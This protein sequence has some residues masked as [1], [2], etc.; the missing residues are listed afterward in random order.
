LTPTPPAA[1][2][3]VVVTAPR[4]APL[5]GEAAF[6]AK[7]LGPVEL[8]RGP[9]LDDALAR[10]PGVS[11]F[12]RNGSAAA[13]PTVQGV[14]LRAI[15]PSGAGRALVLL[16]GA[17]V[18]DPFGGWVIWTALPPE[19]LSAA[20][21]VRGAGAGPYGAGALTG[22]VSL[23]EAAA[24]P[25]LSALDVSAGSREGWRIAAVGG[26]PGVLISASAEGGDGFIPV[27]RDRRGPVDTPLK[28][29]AR[30]AAFRVQHAWGDVAGSARFGVYEERRGAGLAGAA[31]SGSGAS[32][33][34][35]LARPAAPATLGWRTQ[36]WIR[37]SDLAN[38]SVAVSAGRTIA[39][40][41]NEQYST[42]ALGVGFNAAVQAPS[43]RPTTW[44]LGVDARLAQGV[45]RERFR[46]LDGAFTRGRE[47]GGETLVAGL[48]AEASH[49]SGPWLA[50]GGVRLDAWRSRDATRREW[51]L[52]TGQTTLDQP[53][54]DA[55]G[56]T[57][58]ARIGLR[59][60]LAGT[61]YLRAA[62]YAGFRPPTLNELHRPFRVGNDITEANPSLRPERLQG[63]EV[64]A[65]GAGWTLT[66]F[67]NRLLDPITNVTLGVGPATFPTAGFVPAGGVLRRR[68]N[69]GA[70][71]AWGIEGDA[72]GDLG[73]SVDWRLAFAATRARVD[74]GAANPQLTGKRPA[75]API[76]SA[77]AGADWRPTQAIRFSLDGV[78]ESRRFD[79]DLNSRVLG[80][81]L[82]LDGRAALRIS[83][84]SELYL[85][86]ENLAG[87]RIETAETADG[88]ESYAAPRTVR[89][90]FSFRR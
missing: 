9:R 28:L 75:Q 80:P 74:G 29:S 58:T 31:A 71:T 53:S 39:T 4:L 13:N 38:S 59:Y 10:T 73:A 78:Y 23:Q 68:Q 42:P 33:T 46:F 47:A 62:A 22:V 15:A 18:N 3:T 26:G 66:V 40:P 85:A 25:A 50:T 82:R 64:G 19:A 45:E 60:A 48:Y 24:G 37:A 41:A 70:I 51:D 87:A 54:P 79:D 56:T 27:D 88:V 57:P 35:T 49:G 63:A 1:V 14:S 61:A 6:D 17:P 7:T 20:T 11:L 34:F 44:E 72:A 77:S 32:A 55:S 52:S 69:A 67:Y 36:A 81:G 65:G 5:A 90:G 89:A 30:Q 8:A 43:D 2:D 83:A 84:S 86:A 16:D 21:L 12:R 76:L